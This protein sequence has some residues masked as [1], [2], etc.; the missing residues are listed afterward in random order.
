VKS[1]SQHQAQGARGA[2]SWEEALS[3]FGEVDLDAFHDSAGEV[4][5][6][7][8][9]DM[10]DDVISGRLNWMRPLPRARADRRL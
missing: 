9:T 10:M 1:R 8:L 2:L 4:L 3:L 5:D 7:L 6:S